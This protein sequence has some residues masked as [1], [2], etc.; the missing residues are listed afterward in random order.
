MPFPVLN[1][2]AVIMC[3]HGGKV[4]VIPKTIIQVGGA[5]AVRLGDL[6]GSPIVGCPVVPSPASAPCL[7]VVADPIN[8]ASTKLLI[9]GLPALIQ[10]PGPGGTTSGVPPVPMA[11]LMCAFA[12]Q[13]TVMSD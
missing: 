4:T 3:V 8:W 9:G 2:N 10:K 7:A 11:G 12:G 5:P 1:I 6:M 13:A